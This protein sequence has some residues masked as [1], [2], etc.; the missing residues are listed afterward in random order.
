MLPLTRIGFDGRVGVRRNRQIDRAVD[1][2]RA[3]DLA[4]GLKLVE[5]G[6]DRAVD[7]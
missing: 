5:I 6:F 7:G 4:A 3:I 1:R 2:I